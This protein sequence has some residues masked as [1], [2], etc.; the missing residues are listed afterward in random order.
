MASMLA[1]PYRI[2]W[3]MPDTKLS[4]IYFSPSRIFYARMKGRRTSLTSFVVTHC[5]SLLLQFRLFGFIPKHT[6][7]F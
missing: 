7:D 2:P 3:T 1:R 5:D 4:V 6:V